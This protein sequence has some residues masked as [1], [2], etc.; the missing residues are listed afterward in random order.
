MKTILSSWA[1]H[2]KTGWRGV[3]DLVAEVCQCYS[4]PSFQLPYRYLSPPAYPIT[5]QI[6]VSKLKLI[7]FDFCS[8]GDVGT[9]KKGT[10]TTIVA[11]LGC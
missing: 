11:M 2:I 8:S 6:N 10:R 5:P 1:G 4:R 3:L 7:T 9:E